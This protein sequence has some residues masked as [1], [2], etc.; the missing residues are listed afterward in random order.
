MRGPESSGLASSSPL[1]DPFRPFSAQLARRGA[2]PLD[3]GHVSLLPVSV[4]VPSRLIAFE[5]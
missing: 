5:S 2:R 1:T 4:G 3:M